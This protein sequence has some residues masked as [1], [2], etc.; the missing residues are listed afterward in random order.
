MATESGLI[1]LFLG[2]IMLGVG[3]YMLTSDDDNSEI[4]GIIFTIFG[5]LFL[6]GAIFV[7]GV[8]SMGNGRRRSR[9]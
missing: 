4:I 1:I 2:I 3:I 7:L 6:L 9:R 5:G 8:M